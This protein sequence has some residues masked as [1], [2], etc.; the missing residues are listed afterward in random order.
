M[1]YQDRRKVGN[2]D[3][4]SLTQEYLA[5]GGEVTQCP[6][7]QPVEPDPKGAKKK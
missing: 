1:R 7:I 5:R 4:G 3:I 2:Q 6:T